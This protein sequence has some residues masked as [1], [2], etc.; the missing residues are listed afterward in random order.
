MTVE[1]S[2]TE[3]R[4]LPPDL[5]DEAS[6]PERVGIKRFFLQAFMQGDLDG[7]RTSLLVARDRSGRLVGASAVSRL[8][9]AMDCIAPRP[10]QRL[11]RHT[12]FLKP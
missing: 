7:I 5:L 12:L 10:I 4:E 6:P 9:L 2:V 11:A 1:P 8:E 3:V